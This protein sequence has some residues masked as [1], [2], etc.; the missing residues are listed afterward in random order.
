M[1]GA[2]RGGVDCKAAS[3]FTCVEV[4]ANPNQHNLPSMSSTTGV[5]G[6]MC[7]SFSLKNTGSIA[8]TEVAQVYISDDIASVVVPNKLL[9]G[10]ERVPLAPG[11]AKTVTIAI[12]VATQLRLLNREFNWVVEPGSFTVQVGGASNSLKLSAKFRV[13]TE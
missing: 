1:G 2:K 4:C 9:Q 7:V 6:T 11:E 5:N 8:G 12:D 10:Y 3:P 13:V